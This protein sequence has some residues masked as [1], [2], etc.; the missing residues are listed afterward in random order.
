MFHEVQKGLGMISDVGYLSNE[1]TLL[2]I[3]GENASIE[4]KFK[5][6]KSISID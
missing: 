5:I 4:G 3:V 1:R 2:T 6:L